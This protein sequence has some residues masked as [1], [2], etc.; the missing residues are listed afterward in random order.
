MEGEVEYVPLDDMG[1]DDDGVVS[2]VE[3]ET[4][5]GG[6]QSVIPE[7]QGAVEGEGVSYSNTSYTHS[8]NS[9]WAIFVIR[10]CE[11][12]SRSI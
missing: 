9:R 7:E 10:T 1:G 12:S 6:D 2:G 8:T 4:S 5:F 3:Q 11:N